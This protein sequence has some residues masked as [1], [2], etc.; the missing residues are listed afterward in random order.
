MKGETK[1][2]T[3]KKLVSLLLAMVMA[4]S[5]LA[6]LE[7]SA[8]ATTYY[9]SGDWS[10]YLEDGYAVISEYTGSATS[11]TVPSTVNGYTVTA[12]GYHSYTVGAFADNT[13]LRSVTLP[14]TLT[15]IYEY[16]FEDCIALKSITIPEDVTSI[17]KK[18]FYGCTSLASVTFEGD[19][20]TYIGERAF[21]GCTALTSITLPENLVTIYSYA[22]YG[23]ALLTKVIIPESVT[24]IYYNAFYG[25]SKLKTVAVMNK[26]CYYEDSYGSY[27]TFP[28][29][30]TVY[31]YSGSTTIELAKDQGW[32]YKTLNSDGHYYSW[33]TSN[34]KPVKKCVICGDKLVTLPFTDIS[35]YSGYYNYIAYTSSYNS[36]IKGTSSTTFAPKKSVTKAALITILYRMAG[37]PSV[38][39][40]SNPY[41]DVK[42]TAY[43]YK[44]ALWAY[45]KGITTDTTFGGSKA[46]TREKAVTYLYRYAKKFTDASMSTKSIS[47][48]PDASKVSSYATTAMKWAYKN[49]LITGNSSGKLNPKGTTYR[50]YFSKI[51]YKFGVACDIGN[52]S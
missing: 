13:T 6:G 10:Y 22:F 19:A 28:S 4:L 46:I 14:D 5:T 40:Y 11:V 44:A 41:K 7:I 47:S 35:S 3:G 49:G 48:F 2:F 33:T 27:N 34:S 17:G 9:T 43:Y 39:G 30:A 50:I 45:K 26:N 51:L 12:I 23:C 1:Q 16:A 32:A 20:L 29:N 15:A 52:F 42:S 21:Y 37:S 8:F 25:C 24:T 38:S 31:G 36:F 18:A